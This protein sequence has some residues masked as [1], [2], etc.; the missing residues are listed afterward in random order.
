MSPVKGTQ[1]M[2]VLKVEVRCKKFMK[3]MRFDEIDIDVMLEQM[4]DLFMVEMS[5]IV[6]RVIVGMNIIDHSLLYANLFPTSHLSQTYF[7]MVE[8]CSETLYSLELLSLTY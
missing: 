3:Q 8:D 6:L 1:S 2:V 5:R 4:N 7:I